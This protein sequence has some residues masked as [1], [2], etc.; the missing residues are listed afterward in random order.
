MNE[1]CITLSRSQSTGGADMG[2]KFVFSRPENLK[3]FYCSRCR[4]WTE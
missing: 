1:N 2:G 3:S 4:L